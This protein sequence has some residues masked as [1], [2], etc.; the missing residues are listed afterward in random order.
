MTDLDARFDLAVQLALEGGALAVQMRATLHGIETKSAMDFCTEADRAV[1]RL[2]RERVAA[3][4][5]EPVIGEEEGGEATGDG[6]WVVDPIDGTAG[7]IH[8]TGRWCVSI[9]Y[10]RGATMEIGVIYAPA[11][12]RLF[13]ARCGRGAFLNGRPI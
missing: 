8:G 6:V 13:T 5:G 12:D 2:V 11:T 10:L 4:S 9:A 1:E 3:H 7:Y